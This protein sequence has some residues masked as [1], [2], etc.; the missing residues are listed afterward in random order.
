MWEKEF[1][2]INFQMIIS[3]NSLTAKSV[4]EGAGW[5]L[6]NSCTWWPMAAPLS[7]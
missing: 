3:N 6:M 5:S 4:V 2:C 7:L 1:K